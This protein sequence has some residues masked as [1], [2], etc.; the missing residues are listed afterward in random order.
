MKKL[1]VLC[2]MFL[3]F[4]MA[5]SGSASIININGKNHTPS[6]PKLMFFEAGIYDVEPIGKADGGAYDAVSLHDGWQGSW[7]HRYGINSSLFSAIVSCPHQ[8]YKDALTALDHA[9]GTS[10]TLASDANVEFY[11]ID[12][13][14]Y[15]NVG[16]ISLDVNAVPSP[17]AVWLLGSGLVGLV[18]LRKK[19][20]K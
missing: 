9:V 17:G 5:G 15:D 2:A 10:F 1:M 6:S 8:Y 12:N 13:P 20:R 18:G 16:G 3:V 14:H 19:L 11:I 4:G 7:T